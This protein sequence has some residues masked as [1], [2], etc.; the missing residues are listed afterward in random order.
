M[1]NPERVANAYESL[2][3]RPFPR[4]T[5]GRLVDGL[6][7]ALVDADSAGLIDTYTKMETLHDFVNSYG[8][9]LTNV[10]DSTRETLQEVQR[11][12]NQTEGEVNSRF[13]VHKQALEWIIEDL[14][15]HYPDPRPRESP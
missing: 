3:S 8:G 12:I 6:I 7:L 1:R 15:Q 11:V 4:G 14:T 2:I 5:G 9:R 13:L 10:L